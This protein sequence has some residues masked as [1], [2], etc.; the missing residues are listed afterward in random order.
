MRGVPLVPLLRVRVRVSIRVRARVSIQVR[1]G[2]G[3]GPVVSW[4]GEGGGAH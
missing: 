2:E 4:K 3:S 1:P